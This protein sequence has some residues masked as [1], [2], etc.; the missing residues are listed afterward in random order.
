[1]IAAGQDFLRSKAGVHNTYLRGDLNALDYDR[2]RQ[3]SATHRYVADWIGFRRSP[4]GRALR[5]DGF[6]GDG[7]YQSGFEEG[8]AAIALVINADRSLDAPRL[9]F[10][11]NPH[12]A[13]VRLPVSGE[14][15]S[16]WS[17]I[18]DT[19]GFRRQGLPPLI[20]FAWEAECIRLPG[21][22]CGLWI[23]A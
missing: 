11:V 17:Q 13:P 21:L 9:L 18:A 7:F 2:L 14:D 22:C 3:F 23:E 20:C 10:A 8:T 6:P 5:L 19:E 1:M 15:P 16:A 4:E 12:G